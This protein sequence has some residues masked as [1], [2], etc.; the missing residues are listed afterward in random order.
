[1]SGEEAVK[2]RLV[3]EAIG[4]D[5]KID[6]KDSDVED[7]IKELAKTYGR[8]EEDL[9]KNEELKNNVKDSLVSE[10]TVEFIIENAKVKEIEV[11][12]E[13]DCEH[14]SPAAVC[15]FHLEGNQTQ[16]VI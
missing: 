3:I 16:K 5:A 11:E 6:V 12:D 9:L 13:C 14:A 10:K 8:K 15:I 4:K 2:V 1:M 7:R